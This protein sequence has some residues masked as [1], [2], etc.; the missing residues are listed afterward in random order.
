MGACALRSASLGFLSAAAAF[1]CCTQNSA[2][3][4]VGSHEVRFKATSP[5]A[6]AAPHQ[7]K[8]ERGWSLVLTSL[9]AS[10]SSF[11]PIMSAV[12]ARSFGPISSTKSSKSTWPPTRDTGKKKADRVRQGLFLQPSPRHAPLLLFRP[13][14][15][16]G[17]SGS[18]HQIR[19]PEQDR[20]RVGQTDPR[21]YG[22]AAGPCISDP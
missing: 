5:I 4:S 19:L 12:S 21:S 18:R 15:E 1:D 16:R 2:G 22:G 6:V 10:R 14:A 20:R 8:E 17:N 7:T 9:K 11:T 3:Q 13:P